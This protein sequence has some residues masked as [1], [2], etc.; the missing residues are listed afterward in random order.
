MGG[1]IDVIEGGLTATNCTFNNNSAVGGGGIGEQHGAHAVLAGGDERAD[2][3]IQPQEKVE[4]LV[5]RQRPEHRHGQRQP[6]QEPGGHR[7]SA[8]HGALGAQQVHEGAAGEAQRE[9]G[10][11][12][13]HGRG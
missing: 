4:V 9:G 7:P 11:D 8:A 5:D 6:Q 13:R 10:G 3:Q 2:V 12:E 1:G